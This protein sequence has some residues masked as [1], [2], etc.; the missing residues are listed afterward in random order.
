MTEPT[1]IDTIDAVLAEGDEG[2]SMVE[3]EDTLTA[4]VVSD[5]TETAEETAAPPKRVRKSKAA[6]GEAAAPR[7]VPAPEPTQ[8]KPTLTL[9]KAKA[10]TQKIKDAANNS[11]ELFVQAWNDR[12]W[13]S[14]GDQFVTG[15]G[16]ALD[17]LEWIKVELAEDRPRLPKA[18]RLE[19]VASIKNEGRV[20]QSVI[21]E[22]VGMDQ[23]TVSNDLRDAE[24]AGTEIDRESVGTDGKTYTRSRGAVGREKSYGDKLDSYV[25]MV[26][27]GLEKLQELRVEDEWDVEARNYRADF[28]RL[29]NEFAAL[30]DTLDDSPEFNGED[31]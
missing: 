25:K 5:V 26:F 30:R 21:A 4:E 3:T 22:I 18:K 7:E 29:V 9:H 27:N 10:L 15:K 24:E 11:T 13:L 20:S 23:K 12:I 14:Y 6:S 2:H 19:L 17:F 1:T 8:V 28:A 16:A 31:A